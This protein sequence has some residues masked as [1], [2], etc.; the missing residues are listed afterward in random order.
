[1]P[2]C[3]TK[4]ASYSVYPIPFLTFGKTKPTISQVISSVLRHISMNQNEQ[5]WTSFSL[6]SGFFSQDGLVVL[7]WSRLPVF[8]PTWFLFLTV[9][10]TKPTIRKAILSGCRHTRFNNFQQSMNKQGISSWY[11]S[12]CLP[13]YFCMPSLVHLAS[14]F[15]YLDRFFLLE[16]PNH[17]L[18]RKY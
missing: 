16:A 12:G 3:L 13:W 11:T 1:M 18:W 10:S 6:V 14:Y 15:A 17:L 7:F 9:G 2:P 5:A 4:L 8:Q